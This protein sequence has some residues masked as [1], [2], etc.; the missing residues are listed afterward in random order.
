MLAEVH[1]E[2]HTEYK[3][4]AERLLALVLGSVFRGIQR[5]THI[6][7]GFNSSLDIFLI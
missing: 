7:L 4:A 3:L 2:S 6:G 5:E 1:V